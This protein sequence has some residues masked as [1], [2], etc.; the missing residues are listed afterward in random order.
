MLYKPLLIWLG[1]G[2]KMQCRKVIEKNSQIETENFQIIYNK[3]SVQMYI[4]FDEAFGTVP[5]CIEYWFGQK[6][7]NHYNRLS[8]SHEYLYGASSFIYFHSTFKH[9]LHQLIFTFT[10]IIKYSAEDL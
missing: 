2:Y 3:K 1:L 10:K 8:Y 5:F 4:S 9:A 7:N 6:L